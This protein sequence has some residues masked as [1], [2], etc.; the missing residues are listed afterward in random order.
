MISRAGQQTIAIHILL[1]I[2]RSKKNQAMKFGQL[3]KH[4][5]RITVLQKSCRKW[6]KETSFR[7]PFVISK[8]LYILK[9]RASGQHPS[10]SIF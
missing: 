3:I 4:G 10:F 8:I 7:S 6:V 5:V 1:N 9:V 2:S